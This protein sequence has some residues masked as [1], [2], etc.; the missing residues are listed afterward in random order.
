[1]AKAMTETVTETPRSARSGRLRMADGRMIPIAS[2]GLKIGR[3][4]DNDLILDD[5]KVSRYHAHLMPSR[6]GMLV[7]DLASANGIYVDDQ[8]VDGGT[9]LVGGERI[10]IGSTLMSFEAG[11]E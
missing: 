5:P 3:M 10:R 7:K 1:M 6:A 8:F 9:V 4:T 2:S 11:T